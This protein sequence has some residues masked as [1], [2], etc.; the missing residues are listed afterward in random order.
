MLYDDSTI[1]QSLC[2]MV[3]C[4]SVVDFALHKI[5]LLSTTMSCSLCSV[6]L[7]ANA[8]VETCVRTQQ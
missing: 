4:C 7:Q 6:L 2:A 1:L 5:I 8:S 3:M